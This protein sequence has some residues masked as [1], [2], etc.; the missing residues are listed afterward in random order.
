MLANGVSIDL[1][2][3]VASCDD[4]GS[5]VWVGPVVMTH[6]GVVYVDRWLGAGLSQSEL[7]DVDDATVVAMEEAIAGE[8]EGW[9]DADGEYREPMTVEAVRAEL[10]AVDVA[11]EIE[12][13]RLIAE[14]RMAA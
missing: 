9:G 1:S 13:E 4:D 3:V 11:V 8:L 14:I 5:P 12:T 10:A 6:D 7:P 2:Y